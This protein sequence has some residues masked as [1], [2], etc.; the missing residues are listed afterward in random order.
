MNKRISV[1]ERLNKGPVKR[2]VDKL[3]ESTT[4]EEPEKI[5]KNEN[6]K[7]LWELRRQT[8]YVPEIII[9]ALGFKKVFEDKDISEIVREALVSHI[10]DKY[11]RMAEHKYKNDK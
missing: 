6:N 8:Y 7:G 4:T 10:E 11:L 2:P 5:E 1:T 9:D 3:F